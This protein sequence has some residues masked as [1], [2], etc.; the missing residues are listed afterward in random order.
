ML[1]PQRAATE[2]H[3]QNNEKML[4]GGVAGYVPLFTNHALGHFQTKPSKRGVHLSRIDLY[5][6][7]YCK[8]GLRHDERPGPQIAVWKPTG[9]A[10]LYL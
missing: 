8:F 3:T 9:P 2:S 10:I 5:L 1:K 4:L 6:A 7:V